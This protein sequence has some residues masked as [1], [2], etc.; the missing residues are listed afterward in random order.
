M[1]EKKSDILKNIMVNIGVLLLLVGTTASKGDLTFFFIALIILA[2]RTFE[3][4]SVQ[5]KKMVMAEIMLSTTVAV[6]AL[7]QLISSSG[8]RS[9]QVFLIVLLLGALLIMVEAV[10]TYADL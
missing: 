4:T 1:T 2:M 7:N 3:L 5:P 9:Q 10:R 8:G 6:G